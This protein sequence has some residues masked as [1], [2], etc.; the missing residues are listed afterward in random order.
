MPLLFSFSK[1]KVLHNIK[2]GH[3][4]DSWIYYYLIQQILINTYYASRHVLFL[5]ETF[6]FP[7]SLGIVGGN[8]GAS[9]YIVGV[10]DD[11][12]LYLDPHEVQQVS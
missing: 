1:E 12:D 5:Q 11:Q 6:T 2:C 9:T 10:Q 4:Y 7:Q 3:N 8:L